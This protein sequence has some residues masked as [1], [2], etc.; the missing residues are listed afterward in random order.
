MLYLNII[1]FIMQS[2][3]LFLD[4]YR[5]PKHCYEYIKDERYLIREWTIVKSHEEFIQVLEKKFEDA[6]FPSLVS[7]DHDL[8]QEHYN[9][10]MYE[11]VNAY[12]NKYKDFKIP[13][14]RRSAEY[15]V[16]F[17]QKNYLPLPECLIHTMNPAGKIR[18]QNT[19]SQF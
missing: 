9:Q 13:T 5:Y 1:N 17:C 19:L 18:I 4:D 6:E 3:Y 10:S 12:E 7:F 8:H 16:K 15:L 14:G 2:Y 11:G